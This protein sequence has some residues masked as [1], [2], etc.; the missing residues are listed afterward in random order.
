MPSHPVH[1]LTPSSC[2]HTQFMPS[3]P[4]HAITPSSCHHTQFMPSPS[5]CPHT[6]FMPSH[7]VHALTPCIF[8]IYFSIIIVSTTGLRSALFCFI[9]KRIVAIPYRPFF[10]IFRGH[11]V[12][13]DGSDRLSRNVGT[14]LPLYVS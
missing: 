12:L 11:E 14:E 1:A 9:R 2:P 3:H 5:S 10:P 8:V 13:E 6:Q 4:V 7:P